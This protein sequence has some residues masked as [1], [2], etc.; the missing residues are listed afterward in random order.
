M[1]I[2][3]IED[4]PDTQANLA[5]ILALDGHVV[6]IGGFHR[7]SARS[8]RLGS[9]CRDPTGSPPVR[10]HHRRTVASAEKVGSAGR[11][12]CDDGLRGPGQH[13]SCA[14]AR[15][16]RLYSQADQSGC[17]AI[18]HQSTA[19]AYRTRR[20]GSC[21][22]SGWLP[23]DRWRPGSRTKV[24]MHCSEFRQPSKCCNWTSRI[25]PNMCRYFAGSNVRLMTLVRYWTKSGITLGRSSSNVRRFNSAMPG[26]TPGTMS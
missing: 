25:D 23:S 10:R 7:Q 19:A 13:D 18:E 16:G 9:I 2:L 11:D 26:G 1:L 15:G 24:A 5:D 14:A 12:H 3:I 6:E 17:P 20:T 22:A 4:D 21:R 8:V